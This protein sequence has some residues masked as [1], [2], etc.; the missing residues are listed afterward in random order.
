M[1]AYPIPD[2]ALDD[3]LAIVGTSGS[4]KTYAMMTAVERLLERRA[5]VV[6]IDPL[7]VAWGIRLKANGRDPAFP[8]VI[9]GGPR[10]D[11]PI[12]E[13]SGRLIGEAIAGMQESAVVDLSE[14]GSKA[15]ERRFMLGL[16][17]AMYRNTTGE[18]FHLIFDEA[19]LWAPQH[20]REPQ[21]QGLMDNIVRRGRVKGFIPWLITQRPAVISKD[22]LSQVDGL[23]A[24]KLT[25]KHDR[26]AL[27]AWIEGQADKAQQKG[28]NAQLATRQRGEG[29]LWIPARGILT[30]VTFPTKTTFDSSSTPK[31][32]EPRRTADLKPIDIGKLKAAIAAIE[33]DKAKGKTVGAATQ[34]RGAGPAQQTIVVTQ[35]D[36]A[37]LRAAEDRGRAAGFQEGRRVGQTE[38]HKEALRAVQAAVGAIQPSEPTLAA[39][40]ACGPPTSPARP[41]TTKAPPASTRP[42]KV[43]TPAVTADGQPI[44]RP[45]QR[46]LD[47]LR[48]FE[49][50][51]DAPP[52]KE[53]VA[54]LA[55][56]SATSSTF[57][58]NLGRMRTL[59][60]IDYPGP[61]KV[62]L[63][64]AGR[65]IAAEP[66]TA[67]TLAD[68]HRNIKA[69]LTPAQAR[70]LDELI[71]RYPRPM[72]KTDL[73]DAVGAS[74]TSSTFANNLGRMRTLG[75][76]DYPASGM[77]VA[78]S[79]MF[80]AGLAA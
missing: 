33:S 58:N 47:V 2:A 51:V 13:Q 30:P 69:H 32:G 1:S 57:A 73:A 16:L 20:T 65:A 79:A 77:V 63:T 10:G 66:D 64:D 80:P 38:G 53:T 27:G 31:R 68:L 56:A 45:M 40:P 52:A 3:R 43:T 60:L 28:F 6:M 7:G 72:P 62:G 4:G 71:A 26:D 14:L 23:V 24:M 22:I 61:G 48:W 8:V 41:L 15:A 49:G 11:I 17:E 67:M 75:F 76:I 37:A 35:P 5:K 50:V 54:Y 12:T 19:D 34:P 78:T 25:S 21:L 18:P 36:P 70:I 39:L 9:F 74:A 29:I 42:A 46:I 55:E 59:G 44:S